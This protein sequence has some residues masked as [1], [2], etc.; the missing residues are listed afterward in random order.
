MQPWIRSNLY[1]IDN[2]TTCVT[3]CSADG[4]ED[5]CDITAWQDGYQ[6][7]DNNESSEYFLA[8]FVSTKLDI[9]DEAFGQILTLFVATKPGK[10]KRL[11]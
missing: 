8:K 4:R 3:S 10:L 1:H 5:G 6:A 9:F 7:R 2:N 11:F